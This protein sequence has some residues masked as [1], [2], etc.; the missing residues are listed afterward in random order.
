MAETSNRY[1][2]TTWH[3]GDAHEDIGHVI[4]SII[5][6]VKQRQQATDSG[7]AGK[8]GA[9]IT[10]PPGDYHLR[11]QVLIDVSY[12]RIEGSGHGFTSSSIRFNEPPEQWSELHE[13]WPGGSRVLVDLEVGAGADPAEG[14]AIRVARTG[15]PRISSVELIGFCI[16]GLHFVDDGVAANPEN[17]Y[18]NG[19]TGI[20]VED[21]NDSFRVVEMGLVY[22]EHGLVIRRADALSIHDNFIAE[23]GS[24]VELLDWGQASKVT[25]NLIGAGPAGHSLYAENHGGLLIASNNV[26]P[27]GASSVHLVSV[28]RSSVTGNRLHSFYPGMVRLVGGS[29]EN[30]VASNHLLRDHEPWVLFLDVDNGLDDDEGLLVIDGDDNSVIANHVSLVVDAARL[31]PAGTRPVVVRLVKGDENYVAA[32]HVMARE[33]PLAAGD[34]AFEA[35][36]GA[37]LG[38][39]RAARVPVTAVQVDTTSRANTVLDSGTRLEVVIDESV[40][41]FRPTPEVPH[42]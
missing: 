21:A 1:D 13:L 19:R 35:Q 33:A 7:G 31:R 16:D 23:C 3:E 34:S 6:D 36:V 4:N 2:V 39:R 11:T 42:P 10:I 32:N 26:F 8:P 24:C 15:S 37:L 40:N 9:V 25:D 14:A 41:A 12:L 28:S 5:A 38:A 17:T 20:Y 18:V 22:L 27:R 29:S 30:L